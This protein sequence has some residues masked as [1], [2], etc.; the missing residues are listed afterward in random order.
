M[1]E[2]DPRPELA[3]VAC[4]IAQALLAVTSVHPDRDAIGLTLQ[5]LGV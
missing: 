4:D 1:A 5:V 2:R 3:E